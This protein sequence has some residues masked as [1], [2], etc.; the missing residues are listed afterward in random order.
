MEQNFFINIPYK[1]ETNK[2]TS[3]ERN[4]KALTPVLIFN[5]Q[6]LKVSNL[7][8]LHFTNYRNKFISIKLFTFLKEYFF[9]TKHNEH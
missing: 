4:I 5:V 1:M 7:F 8:S 6:K 9:L 3:T 2:N